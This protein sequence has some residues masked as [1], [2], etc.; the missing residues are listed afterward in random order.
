MR[1]SN[2]AHLGKSGQI[3][4]LAAR[5]FSFRDAPEALAQPENGELSDKIIVQIE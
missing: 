1:F 2:L 3:K 4:A 5:V